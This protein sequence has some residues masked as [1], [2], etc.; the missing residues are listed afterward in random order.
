MKAKTLLLCLCML[1]A[2]LSADVFLL[3]KS[4]T[5][6]YYNGG[7]VNPAEERTHSI[8]V[9]DN[10]MALISGSRRVVVDGRNQVFLFI[11]QEEKT[12]V[13]APLPLNPADIFPAPLIERMGRFP[14]TGSVEATNERKEIDGRECRA[15][16][17]HSWVPYEGMKYNESETTHWYTSETLF[18]VTAA[19]K[20][21]RQLRMLNS[22]EAAYRK[23]L[24]QIPGFSLC[25]DS[26]RYR[27]GTPIKS[28]TWIETMKK[29]DPPADVYTVPEGFKV[30]P[31]LSIADL[32]A[33]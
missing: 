29:Q 22:M 1:A 20:L 30:K 19:E 21:F 27:E 4:R 14:M 2:G 25:S 9:G 33:M 10:R 5:E 11:N 23:A 32:R 28:R 31:H 15:Y 12:F 6:A 3:Q 8:W 24:N 7:S 26:V 13:K 18:D 16:R 17:I